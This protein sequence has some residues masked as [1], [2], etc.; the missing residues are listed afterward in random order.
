MTAINVHEAKTHFSSLI[1]RAHAGEEII[2]AKAGKPWAKLSKIEE[3]LVAPPPRRRPGGWPEL[4]A[5]CDEAMTSP[6]T[7][8]DLDAWERKFDDL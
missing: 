4:A 7:G 3:S 1:D 8:S 2:I 6:L 5:L